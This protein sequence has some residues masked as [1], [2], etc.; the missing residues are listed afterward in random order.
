V[1]SR[2]AKI[3]RKP[4][5]KQTPAKCFQEAYSTPDKFQE[6]PE[7]LTE[8]CY[9]SFER[10]RCTAK[11]KQEVKEARTARPNHPPF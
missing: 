9:L 6:Q 8:P 2:T 7:D 4:N 11:N 3:Q 1:S 10:G 5:N